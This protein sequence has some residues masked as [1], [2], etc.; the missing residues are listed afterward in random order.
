MRKYVKFVEDDGMIV[1][2]FKSSLAVGFERG[3]VM[4]AKNQS[5]ASVESAT[6]FDDTVFSAESKI[7]KNIDNVLLADYLVPV[8]NES[9][10]HFFNGRKGAIAV[11][12]NVFVPE[13]RVSDNKNVRL[14]H[15]LNPF[16]FSFII[17]QI[18][19]KIKIGRGCY[20]SP[21]YFHLKP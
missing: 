4:I 11:V 12:D 3:A 16:S 21:A 14:S 17:P 5:L 15:F 19:K 9:F 6:H 13:M 1:N 18:F 10:V 7:A 8:A 20:A 2:I